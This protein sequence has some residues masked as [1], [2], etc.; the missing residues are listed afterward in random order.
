M[1]VRQDKVQL[2]IEFIT[3]ESRALAKANVDTK[4]LT[5]ELAKTVKA[6]GDVSDVMRRI[7]AAGGAVE[8]IDLSKVAP[9]QL[10]TRARQL[11]TALQQ[12]PESSPQ[13][14]KFNGEL[15][16]INDRLATIR[17]SS[18]GVAEGFGSG[19]GGLLGSLG[20]IAGKVTGI[21]AVVGAALAAF[22]GLFSFIAGGVRG[23][24]AF[25]QLNV[26]LETFL[27]SA[28]KAQVVIKDLNDFSIRTPFEPEQVNSAGRALLA[29]GIE[30][31]NLIGVLER[32]GDVASGT[33]K[34]FNELALIY[35]KA[36]ASGIIQGEELN[37]LA[38]AG[39]PIYEEL[40][41]V[42]GVNATEIRKLGEQGRLSFDALDA[43]FQNLTAEGGR[44]NGLLEKQS[45]TLTGLASTARG[46]F[47][48][49]SRNIGGAFTPLLK[50]ILPPVISLI[51]RITE[52]VGPL[53]AA[54]GEKLVQAFQ[55]LS[56][57]F[58]PLVQSVQRLGQSLGGLSDGTGRFAATI[59]LLG[60]ALALVVNLVASF[61]TRLSQIFQLFSSFG[62]GNGGII[63]KVFVQPL[64]TA[65]EFLTKFIA[66]LNGLV[67][68]SRVAFD[69]IGSIGDVFS[70]TIGLAFDRIKGLFT[71]NQSAIDAR[72]AALADSYSKLGNSIGD[73]FVKGYEDAL[74]K[75]R[76]PT[77]VPGAGAGTGQ[78]AVI[79]PLAPKGL[80][81]AQKKKAAEEANE[82]AKLQ[83]ERARVQPVA[84]IAGGDAITSVDRRDQNAQLDA[85]RAQAEREADALQDARNKRL[86]DEEQ[87]GLAKLELTRNLLTQEQEILR[88][89]TEEEILLAFE[90]GEQIKAIDQQI[91]DAKAD[92]A[93]R[94]KELRRAVTETAIEAGLEGL[95][96]TI[97]LLGRNE[98][99]QKRNA[100]ALKAFQ[101]GQ[102]I[103]SG[104]NELQQIRL[105][106]A[107]QAASVAAIPGAAIP[108]YIAGAIRAAAS[109]AQ[110]A[111]TVG[112]ISST[113]F[114][115]GGIFGGNRHSA[116]GTKGYFD[117]GTQIEVEQGETFV[118][119]NRN[120]TGELR[121]LSDL[122]SRTGGVPFFR[123]GGIA[124]NAPNTTPR[125]SAS[126][127][128][129]SAAPVANNSDLIDEIRQLRAVTANQATNLRATVVYTE[130]ETAGA[131]LN[132][133]RAAAEV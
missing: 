117:D 47:S 98:E 27:G 37:Q 52:R 86:I 2:N 87:F 19:K 83:A 82:L 34:D 110:T 43:V 13:Y 63:Q 116:G 57:V 76:V 99:A 80:T 30:Q 84:T 64:S 131:D 122:N 104:L 132:S 69:S 54:F 127:I 35:G 90:K 11:Q 29:F 39:I 41:K 91:F 42:V 123:S 17:Q 126:T 1:A 88:T 53:A 31:E 113:K 45:T 62:G 21:L 7:A 15:K 3:D 97:S 120:A 20:G 75:S 68:A 129:T 114:Q 22:R 60:A 5:A 61:I 25:E 49:L 124:L 9:A 38:E 111:V 16:R 40:G 121:N 77:T 92:L 89:G 103:V 105:A 33:G 74:G 55:F 59:Q 72:R 109:I 18:R 96:A 65:I 95:D 85:V 112:K 32:V 81:D 70:N 102:A 51:N 67:S 23:A 130:L 119:L 73:A 28:E 133:A 48:E 10:I 6:G 93:E 4:A 101:K 128:A 26:S 125:I 24:A 66:V 94:E 115:R 44:F 14:A 106:T 50:A 100:A 79:L 12:I 78:G 8:D 58:A 71:D 118:I 56:R 108:V 107:A 36:R 46:A